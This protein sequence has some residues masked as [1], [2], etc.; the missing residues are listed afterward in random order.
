MSDLA[1]FQKFTFQC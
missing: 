1:S